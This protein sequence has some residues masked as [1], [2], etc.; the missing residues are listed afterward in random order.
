MEMHAYFEDYL[1]TAQRILGDMLDFAV[2]SYGF[3]ADDFFGMFIV[4]GVA[5]Q[6]Q[7]GNPSYVA[8][9]TGCEIVKEVIQK[10]DRKSVV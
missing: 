5:G 7:N 3:D 4:S 9:K 2:N 10:R 1:E 6:F 8:G